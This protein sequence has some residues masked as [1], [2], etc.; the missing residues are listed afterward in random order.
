MTA[1]RKRR[2]SRRKSDLPKGSYRVLGGGIVEGRVPVGSGRIRVRAVHRE[3]P[4][5]RLL[6]TAIV[7]LVMRDQ[8]KPRRKKRP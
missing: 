6:A 3:Q 5:L 2:P 8:T 1:P 7:D 4:D